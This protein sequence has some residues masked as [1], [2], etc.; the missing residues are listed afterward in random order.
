[1]SKLSMTFMLNLWEAKYIRSHMDD[2]GG[3]L[4]D[5][6]S[7]AHRLTNLINTLEGVAEFAK[8]QEKLKRMVEHLD[9]EGYIFTPEFITK[10]LKLA[11]EYKIEQ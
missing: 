3:E 10:L 6:E 9:S 8:K 4:I 1:M 2:F 11:K 7:L 5:I